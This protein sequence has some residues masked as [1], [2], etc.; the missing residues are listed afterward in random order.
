M[1]TKPG[2]RKARYRGSGKLEW[3]RKITIKRTLFF[4]VAGELV[5]PFRLW[6]PVRLLQTSPDRP[7]HAGAGGLPAD[8]SIQ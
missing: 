2:I 3:G 8:S 6:N 1:E 5:A 7:Q 4:C